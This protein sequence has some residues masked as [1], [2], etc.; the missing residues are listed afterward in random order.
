MGCEVDTK[1]RDMPDGTRTCSHCGS[2][3]PADFTD[4]MW[5]YSQRE[6]G[7]EFSRTDKS[8]KDYGNRP[9]VKNASEGGIKFYGNH[10]TSDIAD[11]LYAARE[12]ALVRYRAEMTE[13]WGE[14]GRNL[15]AER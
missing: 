14:P 4:I 15:V 5:R 3:H 13:R 8:Y 11:E 12:L 9:G 7:Y 2:L 1:W 6:E 10:C